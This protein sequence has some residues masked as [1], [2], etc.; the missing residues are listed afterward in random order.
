MRLFHIIGYLARLVFYV[1]RL[2]L[3]WVYRFLVFIT[4]PGAMLV[5]PVAIIGATLYFRGA[6]DRG[7]WANDLN[8]SFYGWML[9]LHAQYIGTA[10]SI[11]NLSPSLTLLILEVLAA[12]LLYVAFVVLRP[13]IGT[14]PIIAPPLFPRLW[15]P[16]REVKLTPYKATVAAPLLAGRAWDGSDRDLIERLPSDVRAILDRP[17]ADTHEQ[18]RVIDAASEHP[19]PVQPVAP[20]VE[21]EPAFNAFA[22]D[23]DIVRPVRGRVERDKAG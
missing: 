15:L 10:T 7:I 23:D 21:E 1:P 19:R 8:A 3:F 4:K 12:P 14:L 9:Q 22:S 16:P 18:G 13:I 17:P 6:I 5:L 2:L 20:P 11:T